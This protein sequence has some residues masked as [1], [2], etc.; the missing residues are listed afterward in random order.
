MFYLKEQFTA[1]S[2]TSKTE[3]R[4]Q[5]GKLQD[6]SF[7]SGSGFASSFTQNAM[8]KDLNENVFW[9]LD[10]DDVCIFQHAGAS[11]HK[12][13]VIPKAL[14]DHGVENFNLWPGNSLWNLI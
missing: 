12:E 14:R 13:K 2:G 6:G 10:G 7:S 11:W 5:R 3:I 9:E 4:L 1:L 8:K